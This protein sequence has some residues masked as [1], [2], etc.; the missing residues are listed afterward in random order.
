LAGA[1]TKDQVEAVRNSGDLVRLISDYVP[2]KPAGTRLKGLC[3]FHQEKTPSFSVDPNAQLFYCFGCNTGGDAFK[4][5]MLY[6]KLDFPR[7]S[8]SS[9]AGGEL[10]F[11]PPRPPWTTCAGA[12]ST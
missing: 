3:P 11:P 2:L 1:F 5:V 9:R 6:E 4:F 10:R 8:I 7:R 12:C